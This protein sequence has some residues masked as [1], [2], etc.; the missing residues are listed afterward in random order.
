MYLKLKLALNLQSPCLG[1]CSAKIT[2]LCPVGVA[3]VTYEMFPYLLCSL[4]L[5]LDPS[6]PL[7]TV[8]LSLVCTRHPAR[9][10]HATALHFESS[11]E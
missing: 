1:L 11:G 4:C 6:P 5:V 3:Y 8:V 2:P 10:F 9:Y 7:S